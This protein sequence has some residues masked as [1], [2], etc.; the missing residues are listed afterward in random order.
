[1]FVGVCV[2]GGVCLG[3]LE[4]MH[5]GVCGGCVFGDVCMFGSVCMHGCVCLW[6][7]IFGCVCLGMCACLGRVF[8]GVS[9]GVCLGVLCVW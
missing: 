3:V 7:C 2:Y 1:M 9:R 8:G 6:V 4:G 5:L